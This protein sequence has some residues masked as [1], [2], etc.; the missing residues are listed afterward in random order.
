VEQ[1]V[2]Q[3]TL[4]GGSEFT[5]IDTAPIKKIYTMPYTHIGNCFSSLY[6]A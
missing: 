5:S 4:G 2:K 6:I 3:K 1:D